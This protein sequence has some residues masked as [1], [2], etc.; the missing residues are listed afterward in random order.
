MTKCAVCVGH[1]RLLRDVCPL[2]DGI[3][4]WPN[5]LF[6]VVAMNCESRLPLMAPK[7]EIR[8]IY[9]SESVRLYQAY[10]AKI[11]NAA[12]TAN[13][14]QAPLDAG[15]WSLTR[16]TWV[17][18]SAVWMA[19]RC[20]WTV[21]KDVNQSRVIALDVSRVLLENMLMS[22][23]LS[24][25]Q[26]DKNISSPVI[27]QWDPE[28]LFAP[29]ETD[30]RHALTIGAGSVRS[31]QIGLRGRSVEMLLDP[32]FVLKITDVT[33]SFQ[34]AHREL[35]KSPP[36]VRAAAAALW[37]TRQEEHMPVPIE[38]QDVL[39]MNYLLD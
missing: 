17:K 1:G 35:T 34:Q 18:P 3:P 12:V 39:Q 31:I 33:K 27:I 2:C 21:M 11:A 19:Y 20:G 5:K 10:N 30:K 26:N 7:R 4:G 16:M 32:R 28:R 36:D 38:V 14:F 25:S 29:S 13:S 23:T 6:S 9:N 8:A 15:N 37:P 22:A 24:H